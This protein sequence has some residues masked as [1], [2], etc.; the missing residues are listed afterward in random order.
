MV[1]GVHFL[2]DDPPDLVGRKLLRVNLSDLAA[3]GAAPLGY[4]LTL[5]APRDAGDAWFAGLR[6][7]SGARPGARSGWRCWAATPRR[8]PGRSALSLTILGHVAP[9]QAVRRARRAGRATASGSP[10]RS[11]TARSGCGA[12]R[13]EVAD[14][15]GFLAGR[16]RL[17][18]PRLGFPL[19]AAASAA[20]MCRTGWCRTS[21]ISAG[22]PGSA[23]RSRPRCVPLSPAARAAGPDWLATCLTGG[24]DYEL[25]MAVPP[26][27][28]AMLSAGAARAG[29]PVTRIGRFVAGA[30]VVTVLDAAGAL[31]PF[32]AGGWSHF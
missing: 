15:D 23:P 8:P 30:P 20:W 32:A 28:E 3:M 16:Y 25:L 11:A 13:G 2:P 6:R 7:R 5:A 4:L 29:V 9:G 24:D 27:R 17:P 1:A 31:M 21:A 14:P 10:A 18:R 22:P 19:E 12:L 26:E